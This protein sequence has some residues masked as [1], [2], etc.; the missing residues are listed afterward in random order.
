MK[1]WFEAG[2]NRHKHDARPLLS[3]FCNIKD[4]FFRSSFS[5]PCGT[6]LLFPVSKN[7][8]AFIATKEDEL[9]KAISQN[10]LSMAD[11]DTRLNVGEKIGFAAYIRMDN[12]FFSLV[13]AMHGPRSRSFAEFFNQLLDAAGFD[14]IRFYCEPFATS[15]SAS[16]A[17]TFAFK[18]AVR[19]HVN[20]NSSIFQT[21]WPWTRSAT[22]IS[23]MVVEIR[24]AKGKSMACAFDAAIDH[25]RDA[26]IDRMT[27][28]AK[29]NLADQIMDYYIVG[30]STI[31][32]T[33]EHRDEKSIVNALETDITVNGPLRQALK[34]YRHETINWHPKIKDISDLDHT[35]GWSTA[36]LARIASIP[37]KSAATP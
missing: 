5:C 30:E 34:D 21:L 8:Y 14:Q 11:I 36:V 13:S 25:S 15:I 7:I 23:S 1:Y 20:Q 37:F 9:I 35:T 26:G 31:S 28:R 22:D 17:K 6:V 16:E 19:I 3:A 18:S 33:V 32:G 12:G 2:G 10:S 27:V 4:T 29:E 24:P